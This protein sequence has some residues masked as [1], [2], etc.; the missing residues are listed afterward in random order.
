MSDKENKIPC[1]DCRKRSLICDYTRP[2]CHRCIAKGLNC[3]GYDGTPPRQLKWLAPGRVSSRNRRSTKKDSSKKKAKTDISSTSSS[4][5]REVTPHVTSPGLQ[6]RT[7]AT[8]LGEAVEYCES[9]PLVAAII[10]LPAKI[11]FSG[12]R[13]ERAE[14]LTCGYRQLLYLSGDRLITPVGS[15]NERLPD[16]ARGLCEDC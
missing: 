14:M 9:I 1:W 15:P 2:A 5:S 3:A 16:I 12:Q 6:I 7:D 4:T 13:W 10:F 8:A 11:P